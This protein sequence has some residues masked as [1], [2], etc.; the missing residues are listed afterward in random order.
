MPSV[1]SILSR[2][3]VAICAVLAWMGIIFAM[4]AR[5]TVPVPPGFSAHLTS[6]A[7][8]FGVYF[9]L[10]IFLWWML[11]F[12]MNDGPRRYVT[13]WVLSVLYGISDEW[14]Q[15]FVPGRTPDVRD[16]MTDAIGAA[17]GLLFVWW[18]V[19]RQDQEANQAAPQPFR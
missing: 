14:H 3:A 15:A 6:I 11:S 19:R 1:R 2:R 8:H 12:L 7:G 10:A 17:C 5:E 18:L 16:V 13:A 9:V 4:S